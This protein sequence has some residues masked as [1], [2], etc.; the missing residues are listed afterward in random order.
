MFTLQ[1]TRQ[2]ERA[3]KAAT[4][5][6]STPGNSLTT[7]TAGGLFVLY[8]EFAS[9]KSTDQGIT[10]HLKS[11]KRLHADA[12]LWC[13]GR[14]G[15]TSRLNLD[16]I[17]IEP[18]HRGHLAVNRHYQTDVATVYGVGD[19][20][21]WP[22]LASAA[23]NQGRSAAAIRGKADHRVVEDVATGIYTIPEISSVGRTERDLTE[24]GVPYEV[25]RAVFK[26]TARG[27]ISGEEVGML[28]L[29]FQPDTRQLLG[30]HCFGAEA[31]EIVHIGQAIMNQPGE[32]NT[33]DYF[34][35][36]T[37]NYPTMAEAYRIA[38]LNGVNR[39]G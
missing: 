2:H 28:K 13:N 7:V 21:G 34:I 26:D 39:L 11:G 10:L 1:P 29:L 33:I 15:N 14:T 17:G 3:I 22:S 16:A 20:I 38:A 27:Q 23:Y 35:Q 30:V 8:S 12:L 36:T 19:V 18:D 5:L 4:Y 31:T 9:L 37:F 25:G 6:E 24:S 32:G